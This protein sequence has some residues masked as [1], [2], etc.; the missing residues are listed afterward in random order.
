MV[1]LAPVISSFHLRRPRASGN[2]RTR[3]PRRRARRSNPRHL[4]VERVRGGA[5]RHDL[6]GEDRCR[7]DDQPI[8]AAAREVDGVGRARDRAG[9]RHRVGVS[10]HENADG[11]AGDISGRIVRDPPPPSMSAPAPPVAVIW[12]D[13][14]RPRSGQHL[15]AGDLPRDRSGRVVRDAA[16]QRK[17]DAM[18]AQDAGVVGHRSRRPSREDA[19]AA[20]RDG[21]ARIVGDAAAASKVDSRP[22]GRGRSDVAFVGDA[23]RSAGI[24]MTPLLPPL[25]E[26][27]TRLLTEPPFRRSTPSA[28]TPR[29]LPA[30]EI[31]PII[32]SAASVLELPTNTPVVLPVI[33]PP[34]LLVTVP[35]PARSTPVLLAAVPLIL[36]LLVT[37]PAARYLM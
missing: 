5:V 1:V 22:A 3:N 12:P 10:R 18:R 6:S 21:T 35:P 37:V 16:A 15:H 14:E 23:P 2:W 25:I 34:A 28:L 30:F 29:M 11:A 9:I 26:P 19:K 17:T 13:N 33:E 7:V 27:P 32:E 20:A 24:H 8:G 4:R 31:V 36:P